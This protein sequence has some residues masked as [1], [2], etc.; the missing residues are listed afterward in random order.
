MWGVFARLAGTNKKE[1]P[2]FI[3]LPKSN[4]RRCFA[5]AANSF[6]LQPL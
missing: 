3:H 4:Q 1:T 5:R 2:L 6:A